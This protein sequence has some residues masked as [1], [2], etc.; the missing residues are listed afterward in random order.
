MARSTRKELAEAVLKVSGKLSQ[1]RLTAALAKYLVQERR[2]HELDAIMREV[3]KQRLQKGIEEII[4]TSA[5]PI[6]DKTRRSIS[7][8]MGGKK[9]I[10]N[11]TIDKSVIGGVRLESSE[12]MLDLTVR[13]RL[14]RLKTKG[15]VNK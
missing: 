14:D 13:N 5:H 4:I 6:N 12:R 3:Q 9:T 10:I 2:T 7:K 1:K 11:Q 15:A 8:L